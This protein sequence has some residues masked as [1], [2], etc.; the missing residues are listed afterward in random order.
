MRGNNHVLIIHIFS[1]NIHISVHIFI[2]NKVIAQYQS[3]CKA[4]DTRM[5]QST[6]KVI[7][8]RLM[9]IKIAQIRS[10]GTNP[11]PLIMTLIKYKY[12]QVIFL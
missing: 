11:T 5:Q 8:N 6:R 9:N 7:Y 3:A 4:H 10:C 12:K 1:L 2:K